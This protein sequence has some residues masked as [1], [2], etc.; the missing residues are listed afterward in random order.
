MDI[1]Q[2]YSGKPPQIERPLL[3]QPLFYVLLSKQK[4]IE[5]VY[6]VTL[7]VLVCPFNYFEE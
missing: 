7:R 4:N 3:Y 2:T 1:V 5:E 6:F